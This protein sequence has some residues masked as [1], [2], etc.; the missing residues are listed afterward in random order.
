VKGQHNTQRTTIMTTT[1]QKLKALLK[2][3]RKGTA[4]LAVVVKLL[5]LD[6]LGIKGV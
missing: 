1:K 4:R 6:R 5:Y 3:Q 2:N